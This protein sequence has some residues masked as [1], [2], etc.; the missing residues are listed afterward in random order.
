MA[1]AYFRVLATCSVLKDQLAAEKDAKQA[2]E[3]CFKK[4]Y[5]SLD[6][7]KGK[8]FFNTAIFNPN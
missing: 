6:L 1:S 5:R 8:Q 7:Y 2:M 3:L 4:I